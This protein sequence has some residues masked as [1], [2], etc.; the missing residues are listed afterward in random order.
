M[1]RARI[2]ILVWLSSLGLVA[3]AQAV[4][5]LAKDALSLRADARISAAAALS[6]DE[7]RG[8]LPAPAISLE[9]GLELIL[10]KR[11]PLRAQVA[12][13]QI[14]GSAMN[15]N[16]ECFRAVEGVSLGLKTGFLAPMGR[17]ELGILAGAALSARRYSGT[18]LVTADFSLLA[19]PRLSIP[20]TR[21][22]GGSSLILALPM[23][24]AFRAA[25]RTFSAGL[26][27]GTSLDLGRAAP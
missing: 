26:S 3:G 1:K 6:Y 21:P 4:P 25:T 14:F 15:A 16:L 23:E 18:S 19:E 9:G 22:A 24:Y 10:W 17:L 5:G 8:L 13:S 12:W 7:D 20:L 27:L 11:L 2:L